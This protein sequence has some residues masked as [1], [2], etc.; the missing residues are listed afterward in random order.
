MELRVR[1]NQKDDN[2]KFEVLDLSITSTLHGG[3][4]SLTKMGF[5]F[6]TCL[7]RAR[8]WFQGR[9]H[10]KNQGLTAVAVLL[11]LYVSIYH[12]HY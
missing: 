7:H 8:A 3:Y 10:N 9:E 4:E 1:I 6:T 2:E 12:Y 11:I 5:T